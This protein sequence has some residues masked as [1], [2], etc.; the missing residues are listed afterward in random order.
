MYALALGADDPTLVDEPVLVEDG[1]A[2]LPLGVG[3][4]L[5][6]LEATSW[7]F[8]VLVVAAD[9]EEALALVGAE[10]GLEACT[11]ST[12]RT[13]AV[14]AVGAAPLIVEALGDALTLGVAPLLVTVELVAALDDVLAVGAAPPVVA[15]GLADA[16]GVAPMSAAERDVVGPVVTVTVFVMVATEEPP[17][18]ASAATSAM[19]SAFADSADSGANMRCTFACLSPSFLLRTL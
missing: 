8:A 15:V 14:P 18:G 16:L 12:S 7:G 4:G 6:M 10:G 13:L 3:E 11:T 5:A 1:D 2:E 9:T 19:S 17:F